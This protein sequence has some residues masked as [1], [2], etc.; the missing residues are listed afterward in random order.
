MQTYLMGEQEKA[1][2]RENE[3]IND[4]DSSLP[5]ARETSITNVLK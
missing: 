4:F 3:R 1:Y 5:T 2:E